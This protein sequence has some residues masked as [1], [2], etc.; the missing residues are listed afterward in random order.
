MVYLFGHRNNGCI[1][2]PKMPDTLFSGIS[3]N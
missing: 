1:K 3:K 2:R